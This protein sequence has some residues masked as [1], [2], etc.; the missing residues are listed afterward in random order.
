MTVYTDLTARA[1]TVLR[2]GFP[3]NQWDELAEK[4]VQDRRTIE[5]HLREE[6][7]S[8]EF[9]ALLPQ[10]QERSHVGVPITLSNVRSCIDILKTSQCT[11]AQMRC[12]SMADQ[13]LWL[14]RAATF[15]WQ[16]IRRKQ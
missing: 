11:G 13:S 2:R 8:N 3:K 10:L 9:A 5:G 1:L 4:I 6:Q 7:P 16:P 14:Q 12:L 15:R